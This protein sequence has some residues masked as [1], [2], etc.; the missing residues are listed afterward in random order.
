MNARAQARM[1]FV[2]FLAVERERNFI[3]PL[4]RLGVPNQR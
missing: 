2:A 3:R 1:T 4:Q